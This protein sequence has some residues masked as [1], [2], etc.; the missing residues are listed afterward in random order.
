MKKYINAFTW[1]VLPN[2]EFNAL[3][4]AQA[5]KA[6]ELMEKGHLQYVFLA[7]DDTGGW[8]IYN[9]ES[10]DA[11]LGF[12]AQLPLRKYMDCNVKELQNA[13]SAADDA[14]A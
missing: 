13:F 12:I 5:A 7:E 14:T 1:N 10:R 2:E 11:V 3:R 6:H 4:P 8:A 9:G